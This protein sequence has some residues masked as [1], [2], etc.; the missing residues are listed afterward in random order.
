MIARPERKFWHRLCL[1]MG[2]TK[3]EL[4]SQLT[5]REFAE[6]YAY[7]TMEPFGDHVEGIYKGQQTPEKMMST[8]RK[9]GLMQ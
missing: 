8:L 1:A 7:Y 3:R 4:Q 5:S 6:W 9:A 2:R